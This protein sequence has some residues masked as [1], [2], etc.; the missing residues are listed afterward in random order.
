MRPPATSPK[1]KENSRLPAPLV[2]S[3]CISSPR[4]GR[5]RSMGRY[6][7]EI[8]TGVADKV[9]PAAPQRSF[10]RNPTEKENTM[11]GLYHCRP[12]IGFVLA[13]RRSRAALN[14]DANNAFTTSG[15]IRRPVQRMIGVVAVIFRYQLR[16]RILSLGPQ[17]Y[18]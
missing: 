7:A 5:S 11:F 2:R 4:C 1:Q 17:F 3:F 18:G 14:L 12:W 8:L 15:I 13:P 6:I 10:N 9:D 16:P